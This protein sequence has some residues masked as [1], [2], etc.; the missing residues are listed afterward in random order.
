MNRKIVAGGALAGLVVA[1]GIAGMVSAQTVA[2]ATGLTEE[3]VIEIALMEV[4]GEVIEVEQESHRGQAFYEVEI[5][6]Q[7]GIEVE[8]DIAAETGEILRV[9][10]DDGDCENHRDDRDDDEDEV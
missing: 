7:D 4:P 1:G 9:K 3:K 8:L 10:E 2:D 6:T 5:L